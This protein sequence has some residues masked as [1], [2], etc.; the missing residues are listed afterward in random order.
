MAKSILVF[1]LMFFK[2]IFKSI[3]FKRNFGG[4]N[5]KAKKE[6]NINSFEPI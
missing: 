4:M 2:T 3:R 5:L 1:R 6:V